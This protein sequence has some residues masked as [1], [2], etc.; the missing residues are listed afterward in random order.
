MAFATREQI[1]YWT[2]TYV[3]EDSTIRKAE[4]D[5]AIAA[6]VSPV[7]F[8][9]ED[10]DN[11]D[12]DYLMLATAAQ[13]V[14]HQNGEGNVFSHDIT[15]ISQDG[16]SLNLTD[17]GVL[18]DPRAKWAISQLSWMKARVIPGSNYS[19]YGDFIN[20]ACAAGPV[21]WRKM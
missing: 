12:L 18:L 19:G 11:V 17:T 3:I 9:P 16:L 7:D 21:G 1:E 5:V 2:G 6:G 15:N 14:R 20:N 10:F 13:A 8:E 4:F